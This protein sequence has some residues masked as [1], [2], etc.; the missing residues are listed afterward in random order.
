MLLYFNVMREADV[1]GLIKTS[2]HK[3]L[4]VSPPVFPVGCMLCYAILAR[5]LL[6]KNTLTVPL[7]RVFCPDTFHDTWNMIN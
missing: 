2:T 4:D 5:V 7:F 3:C 6:L 1:V